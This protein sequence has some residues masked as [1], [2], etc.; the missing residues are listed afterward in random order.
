M[1]KVSIILPCYNVEKYIAKSI[2]SVLDQ[3]YTDFELLVIIDG[4][5]DKSK[6]IAES[7][8]DC[9]I[10]VFEKKNGGLSDARNYGLE[11]A[12]GEFIYFMDSDDWIEPKLLEDNL[13]IIQEENLN[14]I[15]FGYFQ[16]DED[17]H[18]TIKSSKDYISKVAQYTKHDKD[19]RI[20]S[21]QLG[22]MGYAWNKIY[23][24]SFI[25]QHNFRFQKGISLVED[26]LFNAPL[27]QVSDLIRFNQK[28]YYHYI[29][30]DV[31]TLM[32]KFY[33]DAFELKILKS[34]ALE[35]FLEEWGFVNYK[36]VL[37]RTLFGGIRNV[38]HTLFL[39]SN[40]NNFERVKFIKNMF[41]TDRITELKG[42]F[43]PS[44][45]S[46]KLLL[47]CVNHKLAHLFSI[48]M[49]LKKNV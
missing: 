32:K 43:T 2:Q 33:P 31:E 24:K 46:D 8:S 19:L 40:V 25:D 4:S 15:V 13:K 36:S 23:R 12:K 35:K 30:R 29:N 42:F 26:I 38:S 21:F 41:E 49:S 34:I 27:Y 28:A 11:R 6:S 39:S 37:A 47:V 48:M 5:P 17:A 16:D 14:F 10:T 7:F 22:I 18:G 20:D 1:S 44:S 3:S 9:R 45:L